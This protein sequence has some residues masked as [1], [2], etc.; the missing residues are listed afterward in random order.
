MKRKTIMIHNSIRH[1]R[2]IFHVYRFI[3]IK[4]NCRLS[5]PIREKVQ[6]TTFTEHQDQMSIYNFEQIIASSDSNVPDEC[7]QWGANDM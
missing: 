4:K 5:C 6:Q 2:I 3:A 7:D 1:I